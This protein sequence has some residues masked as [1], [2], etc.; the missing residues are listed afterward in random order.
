V[1][2]SL[3]A[4]P[5]GF[6]MYGVP[7]KSLRDVSGHLKQ[8]DRTTFHITGNG[9]EF[10]LGRVRNC[11]LDFLLVGY[12]GSEDFEWDIWA[13]RFLANPTFVMAWVADKEYDF[14]QNAHDPLQYRARNQPYDH[15]PMKSNGLPYPLEQM[16]IDTS[17]NPGR[18]T[19]CRGYHEA[20]GHIMWFSTRFWSLTGTDCRQV[21]KQE[22]LSRSYPST[23]ILR[24]QAS[25][26]CFQTSEGESGKI[27]RSL[28]HLLFPKNVKE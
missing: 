12:Q 16:D 14:W 20:I 21:E 6:Q 5:I 17:H 25:P 3:G 27:Q 28:R 10:D 19:L 2:S 22:Q 23:E 24:I 13:N 15:L 7:L 11:D 1:L 8:R 9:Y 18:C 26:H 4:S